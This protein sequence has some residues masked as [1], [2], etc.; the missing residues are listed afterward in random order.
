MFD[1]LDD[2]LNAGITVFMVYRHFLLVWC[3]VWR[4]ELIWKLGEGVKSVVACIP[5]GEVGTVFLKV[6]SANVEGNETR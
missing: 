1:F 5:A 2:L 6:T 3:I 4:Y